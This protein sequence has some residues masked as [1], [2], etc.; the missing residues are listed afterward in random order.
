VFTAKRNRKKIIDAILF[1]QDVLNEFTFVSKVKFE[2][3]RDI[4]NDMADEELDNTY[5]IMDNF[6][7]KTKKLMALTA[8][9]ASD[10][11]P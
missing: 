2:L 7:K 5:E 8:K 3:T 1:K 9:M 6:E 11:S 10:W 4:L